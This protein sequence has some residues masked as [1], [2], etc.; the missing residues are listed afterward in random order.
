MI[1]PTLVLALGLCASLSSQPIPQDTGA[2]GAWQKLQ[3]V[4][5]TASVLHG[6]AHP[7]DEHGGVLAKL[8]RGDGARVILLTLTRGESGDNA[9]GPQLFDALQREIEVPVAV[10]PPDRPHRRSP[11]DRLELG[12]EVDR[13]DLRRPRDRA[14]RERRLQ[15]LREADVF[16]EDALDPRDEVFDAREFLDVIEMIEEMFDG[17]R[18]VVFDEHPN[19][20][21]AHHPAR[22]VGLARSN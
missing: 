21:N 13:C 7:D 22:G 10:D 9:I 5:T 15:Q 6:T 18:F 1:A 20:R 19:A 14:A 17:R 11:A 2:A 12:D 8:S 4:R 3:K 16:L